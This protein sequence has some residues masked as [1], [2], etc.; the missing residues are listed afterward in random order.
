MPLKDRRQS[1]VYILGWY[2]VNA[3]LPRVSRAG[4]IMFW[5]G[6]RGIATIDPD[7]QPPSPVA[8]AGG[9]TGAAAHGRLRLCSHAL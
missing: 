9:A 8:E 7:C 3:L 2:S 1:G 5:P 4:P 6:S